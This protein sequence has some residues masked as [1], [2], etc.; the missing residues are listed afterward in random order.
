MVACGSEV[1]GA[2]GWR[3]GFEALA[4]DFPEVLDRAS[5]GLAEQRFELGEGV[6]DRLKSGL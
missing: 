6:L 1:V 3:E 5:C 2:F 4:N